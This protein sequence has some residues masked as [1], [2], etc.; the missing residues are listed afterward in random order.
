M[1]KKLSERERENEMLEY[2]IKADAKYLAECQRTGCNK[3]GARFKLPYGFM[4]GARK[5]LKIPIV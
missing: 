1:S 2:S 3:P 4:R 5:G